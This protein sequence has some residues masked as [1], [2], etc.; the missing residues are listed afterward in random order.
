[1]SKVSNPYNFNIEQDYNSYSKIE[2]VLVSL[3]DYAENNIQ[4]YRT[5]T[6]IPQE[7]LNYLQSGLKVS[8][9]GSAF[10][11]CEKLVSIPKLIN[12]DTSNVKDMGFMFN[13]CESITSLDL[14]NFS[15][16]NVTDMDGCFIIVKIL[17]H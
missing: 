7:N 10:S 14:S 5:I 12:I 17:Y 6:E 9:C 13:H 16:S 4:N 8:D 1:M 11:Y 15:T 3:K 2:K